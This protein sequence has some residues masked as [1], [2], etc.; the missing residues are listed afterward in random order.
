MAHSRNGLVFRIVLFAAL[1]LTCLIAGAA[2]APIA[3]AAMANR[4]T[5]AIGRLEGMTTEESFESLQSAEFSFLGRADL[6][7]QIAPVVFAKRERQVVRHSLRQLKKPRLE[8]RGGRWV[9]R[10]D[11]HYV[12]KN[13]LR[14]LPDV[15]LP[16]ILWLYR[17]ADPMTKGN[18]IYV[19]GGMQDDRGV[20]M[21]LLVDALDDKTPSQYENPEVIGTPLRICDL[22]YNQLILR[23]KVHGVIRIIGNIHPTETRELNIGKLKD[24]L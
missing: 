7:R 20:I 8:M 11:S 24:L 9:D 2:P 4:A 1:P 23:Q 22:A 18:L 15:A 14:G 13:I 10:G 21:G 19:L 17:K 16:E 6:M 5:D 3:S 12:A